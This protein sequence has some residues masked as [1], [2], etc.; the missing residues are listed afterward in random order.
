MKLRNAH[1]KGETIWEG[2][3]KPRNKKE[4]GRPEESWSEQF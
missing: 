4:I 1:Y 2:C 3:K